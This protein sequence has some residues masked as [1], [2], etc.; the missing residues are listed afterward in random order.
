MPD[1][2][3]NSRRRW[4][5]PVVALGLLG[6]A[7]AGWLH[8]RGTR[9][10]PTDAPPVVAEDSP[11]DPRVVF[12]TPYRNVAPEVK[13][14]GDARCQPCHV[15]IAESYHQHPMGRS[16]EW[17]RPDAAVDHAAGPNNPFDAAGYHLEVVRQGNR[18]WHRTGL[19]DGDSAAPVYAVPADLA[20][21][22]G[23]RGR[24]YLTVDHGAVWQ[25]PVSWFGHQNRWD[26]SPGFD[27]AKEIRRPVVGRC[28]A[29][30]TDHPD[31]V[32]DSINRYREPLLPTQ[33]AIGCERCHGPGELHVAERLHGPREGPDTSIVNPA[34]LPADLRADVCRQCH[35]Q[36]AAQ[37]DRRGRHGDAFRPGLPWDQFVSTFLWHPDLAD[38]NRSVGQFEQMEASRC[39]AGSG[40][41]LGCTSCHDPHIKP[42]PAAADGYFRDRCNACHQDRGCSLPA[43]ARAAKNDN[44]VGCHM[45]RRDSSNIAH[46]A[47]TDHRVL[48]RPDA[49]LAKAKMLPGGQLPL[50]AYRP[51]PHAPPAA[52]RDRDLA[53][54][55]G[56]EA[57]RS[58]APPGL[59]GLIEVRL[60]RA[61]ASWPADGPAW[62]A[63]SRI[64]S[65]RG[66]GPR[67][68]DTARK[69]VDLN[70]GSEEA[71]N[72]LAGAAVAADDHDTAIRAATRLIEVSPTSADHRMTRATA[73]FSRRQWPEAEADCR[74]ALA[75]QPVRP[76]ARF[77]L[78]VCRHHR[79]DPAGGK[80]EFDLAV[81]LTPEPEKRETLRRWYAQLTK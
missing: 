42:A 72:Q 68:V 81:T 78:A 10:T 21:G 17:V 12:N 18:V 34:R 54:A 23:S 80:R 49:G 4:V 35:L 71:L 27:L 22:S 2:P 24:S 63:R 56:D 44:C 11:P 50:V 47:V 45:P 55:L 6:V 37:V 26:V 19:A 59:W 36:G 57:S 3:S 5:L 48:R 7:V 9:P 53:I 60:D 32:P 25:S 69:A 74:A 77:M 29:C 61:L 31:P 76:N 15:A 13:Y 20:I 41:K 52:E 46:V 64:H 65:A 33:A 28:L 30:H 67:A 14:V 62:L 16:A 1:A 79:G 66:D 75:I 70:P 8:F 43:P 73:Y 40:G 38:A 58:G 39:F 51:G